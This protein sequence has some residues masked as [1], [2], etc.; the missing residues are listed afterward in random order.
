MHFV[1]SAR[2]VKDFVEDATTILCP[3][4]EHDNTFMGLENGVLSI[5]G[6]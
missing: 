5:V 4:F 2:P 3:T 1:S 6:M